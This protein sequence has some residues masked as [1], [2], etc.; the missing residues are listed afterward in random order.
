MDDLT[1][2]QH[3]TSLPS[4]SQKYLK[5]L[6]ESLP[7]SDPIVLMDFAENYSFACQDAIQG[8]N[9]SNENA[10]LHPLLIYFENLKEEL[11]PLNFCVISNERDHSAATVHALLQ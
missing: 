10:T 8:F 3:T 1:K 7:Q 5:D 6:K 4:A 2:L 9:S 11:A